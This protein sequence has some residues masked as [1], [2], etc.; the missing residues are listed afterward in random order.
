[1]QNQTI[2]KHTKISEVVVLVFV[3]YIAIYVFIIFAY[4]YQWGNNPIPKVGFIIFSVL[5]IAILLF[6]WLFSGRLKIIIDDNNV[7]FRSDARAVIKAPIAMVRKVDV[8]QVSSFEPLYF[9]G[10][11]TQNFQ[12]GLSNQSVIIHLKDGKVF[13]FSIKNAQEIKDE[14]EKRMTKT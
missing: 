2:Y 12:F 14:I 13:R 3:I 11:K 1:M 4:I 5:W 6:V 8:K 9:Q 7:I 10:K